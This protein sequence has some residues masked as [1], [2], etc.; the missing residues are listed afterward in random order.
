MLSGT[1]RSDGIKN[2][3]RYFVFN[4]WSDDNFSSSIFLMPETKSVNDIKH[5][6]PMPY[7]LGFC[8]NR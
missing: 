3:L 6:P 7:E 5:A 1:S 4:G 8:W 2:I